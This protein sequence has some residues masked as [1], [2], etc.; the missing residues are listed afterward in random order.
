MDL[1]DHPGPVL[2]PSS[3][4]STELHHDLR[5]TAD[6]DL[7][8]ESA[9]SASARGSSGPDEPVF[10]SIDFAT[11]A[12]SPHTS[13]DDDR[14]HHGD[15]ERGADTTDESCDDAHPLDDGISE[16]PT[17]S[18]RAP[19][20]AR[21]PPAA[22]SRGPA[23]YEIPT[24]GRSPFRNPS[25]VRAIQLDT[26]PP[27]HRPSSG[28]GAYRFATSGEGRGSGSPSRSAT[29]RSQRSGLRPYSGA[30]RRSPTRRAASP[31]A[32]PAR[33]EHP[34]VLL[35]ATVLPVAVPAPGGAVARA[36]PPGV[37]ENWAL[38]AE[39]VGAEVRARGILVPHPREDYDLLEERLLESLALRAPRILQCGHFHLSPEEAAEVARAGPASD[40]GEEGG[41][42]AGGEDVCED[43]G[44]RVRDGRT[45]SLGRGGRRWDIRIYAANGLMR[46]GAWGAAWREMERVDV[47]IQP[48]IEDGL[49]R[50][51][52]L[53]READD[54]LR[55]STGA[56][57]TPS[58]G[59]RARRATEQPASPR[60]AR[61]YDASPLPSPGPHMDDQRRREIY[62]DPTPP[63]GDDPF[64]DA[65]LDAPGHPAAA[66]R[67]P[68][69]LPL[70]TL[71]VNYA[72]LL[73]QDRRN[74]AV[75]LLS[76]MVAFLALRPQTPVPL[77]AVPDVASPVSP[78]AVPVPEVPQPKLEAPDVL[79]VAE[80][81][82]VA[83]E[84]VEQEPAARAAAST[85]EG[86][87]GYAASM[88]LE[89]MEA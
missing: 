66:S 16:L 57:S 48:W 67:P 50:E 29:P 17:E 77:P 33:R 61:P 52:E 65:R 1:V 25:S 58:E 9:R 89:M 73:M 15:D 72:R 26:T 5:S 34:L 18:S 70:S 44:Q 8:D 35:H 14:P 59:A 63:F 49:R 32:K 10:D 56:E 76:I 81:R 30:G 22:A 28:G 82:S 27:H 6:D 64:V 3:P 83:P 87:A 19:S 75:A 43:C 53:L 42:D 39:K 46:A 54:A 23:P 51:L 88:D 21:D 7:S 47:E 37:R 80:G 40:D 86:T 13:D 71:L 24:P 11:R 84:A 36:L 62:G 68:V 69:D 74:V 79:P 85:H 38:L 12:S 41:S 55:R 2:L 45:G 78:A 4:T 20:Y 60:G 31:G